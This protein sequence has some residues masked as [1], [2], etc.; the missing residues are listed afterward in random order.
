MSKVGLFG[1]Y[2][3]HTGYDD[4][5]QYKVSKWP[6]IQGHGKQDKHLFE[7]INRHGDIVAQMAGPFNVIA[8]IVNYE[9]E[10]YVLALTG[11]WVYKV[12]DPHTL[13]Q[14]LKT[15]VPPDQIDP[16]MTNILT[17]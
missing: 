6:G 3:W 7:R 17:I 10:M 4:P 14:Y 13:Y 1:S 2:T 12:D 11:K 8:F 9:N 16:D 15:G 5:A